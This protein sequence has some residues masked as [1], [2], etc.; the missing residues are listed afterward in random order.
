MIPHKLLFALI[1]LQGK[2]LLREEFVVGLVEE[3]KLTVDVLRCRVPWIRKAME[4]NP[5]LSKLPHSNKRMAEYD[6]SRLDHG[7]VRKQFPLDLELYYFVR[8]LLHEQHA[9]CIERGIIQEDI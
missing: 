2:K 8:D 6:V 1:T 7:I 3:P 4:G 5:E 9:D